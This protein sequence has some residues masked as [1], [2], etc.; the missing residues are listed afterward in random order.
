MKM[1]PPIVPANHT[2][3][4]SYEDLVNALAQVCHVCGTTLETHGHFCS[5]APPPPLTKDERTLLLHTLCGL[6][7]NKP[8]Y[9]NRYAAYPLSGPD[10]VIRSLVLRGLMEPTPGVDVHGLLTYRATEAGAAAVG[11]TLP[12]D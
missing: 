1:S 6:E 9:R 12:K 3:A 5:V 8:S 10:E 2:N 11:K 7:H 4:P